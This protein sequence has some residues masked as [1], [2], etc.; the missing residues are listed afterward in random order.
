MRR[1]FS[2]ATASSSSGVRSGFDWE[3]VTAMQAENE[4]FG[5]FH[6]WISKCLVSERALSAEEF[7]DQSGVRREEGEA[8]P[9][10][11]EQVA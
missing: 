11:R 4:D 9:E 6:Q 3:H 10:K 7:K 5:L 8:S 1:S 2:T